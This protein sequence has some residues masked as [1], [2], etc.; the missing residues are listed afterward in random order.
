MIEGEIDAK[1]FGVIN[2]IIGVAYTYRPS[3]AVRRHLT[4][5]IRTHHSSQN[6]L[7]SYFYKGNS[8]TI[9]GN[10]QA[11]YLR[12]DPTTGKLV[13]HWP[14][15]EL[16]AILGEKHEIVAYTLANDLTAIELEVEGR[17]N[18][19]DGTYSGKVWNRSGSV[20]P[21]FI[22]AHIINNALGTVIGLDIRRQGRSIYNHKYS[23]AKR[24]RPFHEIPNA[25]VSY[26]RQFGSLLPPSK[27]IMVDPDGYLPAGTLIMLGTGLIIQKR[28]FCEP[29][30]ILTV[31]SPMIGELTNVVIEEP[32]LNTRANV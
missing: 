16:A 25:I 23:T 1:H 27:Q 6:S 29:Q 7:F 17:T 4:K 9:V 21:N 13:N 28:Y 3:L 26:Y 20:G 19:S 31:Y 30:D 8:R 18:E 11:L 24:I 10:G 32:S 15:A 14:E 12:T 22:A 5:H 2:Q